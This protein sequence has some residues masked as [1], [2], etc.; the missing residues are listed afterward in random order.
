MVK[1]FLRRDSS[2]VDS[3]EIIKKEKEFIVPAYGKKPI[4]IVEG[5]DTIVNDAD[6]NEYID[7]L[8]GISVTNAGH[9][10]DRLVR[11]GQEQMAK[12][13]HCSGVYHN[14]PATLLAEKIAGITP[15][16]LTKSFFVNSGAEAVEGAVKIAKKFAVTQG[17]TGAGVIALEGSFHGRL[18]LSLTLTGQAK[19]KKGFG[20]FANFPGVA[21]APMPYC[22]RCPLSF[23][24]CDIECARKVKDIIKY[25]TTADV[26]AMIVEPVMGEGGIIVPP[27][28]YHDLV[29]KICKDHNVLYIA[30][31][32]QT[33]FGRTGKM[34]GI[35]HFDIKPD[36]LTMAKGLGA[37]MPIG[38]YVTTSEIADSLV[39]GDHFSTFGGNP[40]SCAVA[41]ENIDYLQEEG[42][43]SNSEKIGNQVRKRITELQN[44]ISLIGEVRGKGLMIGV[45]LVKDKK[46]KTPAPDETTELAKRFMKKGVLV[47]TGGVLGNVI[48]FQPPL[49]ITTEQATKVLDIFEEEVKQL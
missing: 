6:G 37:G 44:Q 42:L 14:I 46:A 47:G 8:S 39:S 9:C 41:A 30:D 34:F 23:P 1:T 21:H 18:G 29:Q 25:H 13:I 43:I 16:P 3:K 22:Y 5:K 35:E 15:S 28:E 11:A 10:P 40:V 24:D 31:E 12:L 45:E 2:M 20:T 27:K 19:Y 36:I 26:A 38:G 32:V 49:C 33:G 7:C 48:R 4:V 17:R